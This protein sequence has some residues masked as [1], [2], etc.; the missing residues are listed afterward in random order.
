MKLVKYDEARKALSV[1]VRVDEAARIKDK[2]EKLAA[3]ARMAEDDA[4]ERWAKE[5]SIRACQK[6]GELSA[7]LDK[8]KHGPGRGNKRIPTD[9]KPF[10]AKALADAGIS[11]SAASR[12]ERLAGG[13]PNTPANKVATKVTETYFNGV[14]GMPSVKQLEKIIDEAIVKEV[15]LKPGKRKPKAWPKQDPAYGEWLSFAAKIIEIS[16]KTDAELT[17]MA[18]TARTAGL[19]DR[20]LAAAEKAVVVVKR[21]YGRL[22]RGGKHGDD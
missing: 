16:R 19:Y 15:G 1:C 2:A 17:A 4:M 20:D 18:A 11:T 10:K 22:K 8:A 12:Y 14:E 7:G 13:A 3:Y 9:G 6:V 21:W 5:I